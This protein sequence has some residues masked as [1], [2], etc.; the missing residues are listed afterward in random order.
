[1]FGYMI[2]DCEG[3]YIRRD[4]SSNRH[5]PIRGKQYG[6]IW[7]TYKKAENICKTLPKTIRGRYVVES[8]E[9]EASQDGSKPVPT[10]VAEP[11]AR[12]DVQPVSKPQ[13]QE[14]NPQADLT[15]R[16][17][18]ASSIRHY[19]SWKPRIEDVIKFIDDIETRTAELS[20]DLSNVDLQVTDI[21]HC[22]EFSKFNA[23][24]GYRLAKRMQDTLLARRKVK[25]EMHVMQLIRN[26]IPERQKF[27]GV[28][29]AIDKMDERKYTPRVLTDLFDGGGNS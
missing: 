7:E 3:L 24:D 6:T 27:A 10:V 22:I 28:L 5:V 9:L 17:L 4:A 12:Q 13:A 1:M 25:D 29:E 20:Q 14:Q 15:V 18:N 26:H 16:E 11:V 8:V 21:E 19:E 23:C 2:T